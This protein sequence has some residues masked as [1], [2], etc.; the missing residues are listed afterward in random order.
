MTDPRRR[1]CGWNCSREL[2]AQGGLTLQAHDVAAA[3][4]RHNTG[5]AH[6]RYG[7][8]TMIDSGVRVAAR[9][10]RIDLRYRILCILTIIITVR[11][12][13]GRI[14]PGFFVPGAKRHG[15]CAALPKG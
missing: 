12:A 7:A 14:A 1:S 2:N 3:E 13:P 9:R 5:R 6:L 11:V 4:A 15:I 8:R 10:K